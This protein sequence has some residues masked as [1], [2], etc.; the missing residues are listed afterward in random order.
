MGAARR[1]AGGRVVAA[2]AATVAAAAATIVVA[3]AAAAAAAV[4]AAGPA[5]E[6]AATTSCVGHLP[7]QNILHGDPSAGHLAW[8]PRQPGSSVCTAQQDSILKQ[9]E[10]WWPL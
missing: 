2:A 9:T 7:L 3:V 6:G 1:A 10:L 8:E 4:T 5:A